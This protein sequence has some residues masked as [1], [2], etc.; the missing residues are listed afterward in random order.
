[1]SLEFPRNDISF[2][3]FYAGQCRSKVC[4]KPSPFPRISKKLEGK[5]KKNE[6]GLWRRQLG[7]RRNSTSIGE[8]PSFPSRRRY[9]ST[10]CRRIS[11]NFQGIS[12]TLDSETCTFNFLSNMIFFHVI[13]F[14]K[15]V[16]NVT[17]YHIY[18]FQIFWWNSGEPWNFPA[19]HHFF[20]RTLNFP[21]TEKTEV[22]VLFLF[23]SKF[24]CLI[25]ILYMLEMKLFKT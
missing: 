22:Q 7:C 23:L 2:P 18:F 24:M 21:A 20:R 11:K 3:S 14:M 8:F 13:L 16:C 9:K 15:V 5:E 10:I 4:I 19:K 6:T 17:I 25:C 12:K 1:M